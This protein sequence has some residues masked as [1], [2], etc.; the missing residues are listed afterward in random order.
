MFTAPTYRLSG[1]LTRMP[2]GMAAPY[3]TLRTMRA[4]VRQWRTNVD[5]I[6]AATSIVYLTP[7]K[8]EHAEVNAI[9]EWVRDNVRYMRDVHEIEVI[10]NPWI[11]LHRMVGDCDDKATLLATLFEIAGYPTR[12]V[13]AGYSNPGIFEHVYVQVCVGREWLDA[14]AT[15]SASLGF[16]PAD[17][18]ALDHE[19]V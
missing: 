10:S 6:N 1:T 16:S 14:D 11:T 13:I 12:F 15:E 7:A 2:S 18:V 17:P 4:L 3:A 8:D 19:R 5:L 9:F